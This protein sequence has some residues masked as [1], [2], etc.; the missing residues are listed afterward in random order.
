MPDGVSATT[1]PASSMAA[2]FASAVPLPPADYRAGVSHP[3]AWRRGRAGNETG[4]RL[5]HSRLDELGGLLFSGAAYLANHHHALGL[6]IGFEHLQTVDEVG[7]VDRVASDTH[8]GGLTQLQQG[9]L[10]N[11]FV[12]ESA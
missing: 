6:R 1:I 7:A 4:D 2:I 8:G 9:E 11:R 10:V 3:L 5:G 12:G